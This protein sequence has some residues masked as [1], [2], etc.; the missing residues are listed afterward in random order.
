MK[1]VDV[2]ASLK[3]MAAKGTQAVAKF[4]KQSAETDKAVKKALAEQSVEHLISY[5][6]AIR[7]IYCL[8]MVDRTVSEEETEKFNDIGKQIDPLFTYYRDRVIEE[9]Q[10]EFAKAVDDEDYYDVVHDYVGQAIRNSD[11][12]MIKQSTGNPFIGICL[13][14]RM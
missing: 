1:D 4:T 14:L 10:T 13:R 2:K 8:M 5:E 12:K 3:D 7:I 9:C 11:V 6:D